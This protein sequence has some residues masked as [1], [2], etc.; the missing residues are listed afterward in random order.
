MEKKK[1]AKKLAKPESTEEKKPFP[2]AKLLNR[3]RKVANRKDKE[4]KRGGT[5]RFK[6]V[7]TGAERNDPGPRLGQ[8]VQGDAEE[9]L[10]DLPDRSV[11]IVFTSPPYNFGLEYENDGENQDAIR[12]ERYFAKLG[13]IWA[14]CERVLVDG[15]RLI[16]NVQPLFSDYI[17]THHVISRQLQDLGLLWKGEILW[18]KNNY[19]CK[20]TA[21]GSWKSPSM[22]YLKYTWEFLEIF[23]KGSH[24][25]TG[26]RENIDISGDEFKKWVYAKW[27]I[28]PERNMKNYD[29]PAMFPEELAERVLKLFSYRGDVVLDPFCGAGTTPAVC[30]KHGRSYI[31]F[32]TSEQ[33]CR[34]ARE[35]LAAISE[36]AGDEE[37]T[38]VG[39]EEPRGEG[40]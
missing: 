11:D 25:K 22:P 34:A 10:A 5:K 19:N 40:G 33:Y 28:A 27:S 18:E 38:T 17:P 26:E 4:Q 2:D 20:Y 36:P 21:W 32:D 12:W 37:K 7:K 9:L 15:G 1:T 14:E 23:C 29:H 13:A 39:E 31:G 6:L 16:V 3:E 30:K 8:I 35:R 24:K